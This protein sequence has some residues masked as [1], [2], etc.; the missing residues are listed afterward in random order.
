MSEHRSVLKST[1]TISAL[2]ILSRIFGYIRDNRIASLL[3]TGTLGDAYSIAFRIPNIL[4][5]LVGEGAVSAAFIPVFSRYLKDENREEAWKFANTLLSAMIVGMS[6]V[7]ILG[8][9]FSPWIVPLFAYGFTS[10][11]GKLEAATTLNRIMF[12]F[13][14][15]V[16]L[17]ALAMGVLNSFSKFAAPAFAPVLLNVGI[18]A[19]SFLSRYFP[20]PAEA[21]AV[22]VVVGGALQVLI[23]IPS[24]VRNGWRFKW[25]WDLAH[26]GVR[27][28]TGLMAPRLFGI[29]IVQVDVLVGS[30]F[31]SFMVEGSAASLNY[32]DRVME[33]VLG[34]YAIA[35]STA[36]LPL[37]SRQAA[38]NR[39]SELK[40]TIEFSLR[41]VLFI[42]LPATVGLILLRSPIIEVL[43]ERGAFDDRS[44]AMTAWALLYFAVG[45]SAFSMVKIVVQAYYALHDTWTPVVVGFF[46]L[47]LNIAMNFAF[48]RSLE[49]GGPA[50]ATS[51]AAVFDTAVLLWL[52]ERRHGS[53]GLQKVILSCRKFA[54]ASLVMGLIT[55]ALIHAPGFYGGAALQRLTALAVTIAVATA[56]YFGT[57]WFLRIPELHEAGGLLGRRAP[58]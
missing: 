5:R 14:G 1:S 20:N 16:S 44:T 29:G 10:T 56:A 27:K 53:L 38:E 55:W 35:L 45:L 51:L 37:L 18:I 8:V 15:L 41:M 12:P 28:V 4:R 6:L 23:Q 25:L 47:L 2:T 11:P 30:Q 9:V 24:L 33:L 36:I 39:I 31:A 43:F 48:F 50:L 32:A 46:S 49:N 22:G 7:V 52:F 42:T 40:S 3:G 34:G 19:F 54:A 13:I 57:A 26:P 58:R 21:L 17:S